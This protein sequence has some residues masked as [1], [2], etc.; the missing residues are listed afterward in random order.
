MFL[1]ECFRCQYE[2]RADA[3][4]PFRLFDGDGE[5]CVAAEFPELWEEYRDESDKNAALFG[6]KGMH[7]FPVD[8]DAKEYVRDTLFPFTAA[9]RKMRRFAFYLRSEGRKPADLSEAELP[10][11]DIA[12]LMLGCFHTFP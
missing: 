2:L 4:P 3:M 1:G 5:I 10:D 6:D 7:A 8:E 9:D 12:L 11:A